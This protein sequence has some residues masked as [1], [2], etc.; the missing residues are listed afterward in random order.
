M[1]KNEG[2]RS[3]LVSPGSR[4]TFGTLHFLSSVPG[5]L[6][7]FTVSMSPLGAAVHT[8]DMFQLLRSARYVDLSDADRTLR[9]DIGLGP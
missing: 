1:W 3:D 2:L 7:P 9:T 4:V 8:C 6:R 5:W